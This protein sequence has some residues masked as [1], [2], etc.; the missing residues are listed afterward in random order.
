MLLPSSFL[1]LPARLTNPNELRRVHCRIY[2]CEIY[3]HLYGENGRRKIIVDAPNCNVPTTP[4]NAMST[5]KKSTE[6][7]FRITHF[8]WSSIIIAHLTENI[9]RMW[10]HNPLK[11]H[12]SASELLILSASHSTTTH[13]TISVNCYHHSPMCIFTV[14]V[15]TNVERSEVEWPLKTWLPRQR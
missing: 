1:M 5:Q 7:F 4:Q 3:A 12:P 2:T 9:V 14:E 10:R 6:F 8:V 11:T 13:I 15:A